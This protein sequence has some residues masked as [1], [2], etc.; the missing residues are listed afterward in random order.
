[1]INWNKVKQNIP[2]R[3]KVKNKSEYETLY[4]EELD[5]GKTVGHARFNEKQIIIVNKLSPKQTVSTWFHELL[6]IVSHEYDANL[7]EKQVLA[8]EKAIPYLLEIFKGLN[9]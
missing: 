6:H 1:M 2:H 3:F 9:S 4:I 7:T 8:L 5:G